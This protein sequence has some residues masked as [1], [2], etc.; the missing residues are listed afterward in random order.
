MAYRSVIAVVQLGDQ[1]VCFYIPQGREMPSFSYHT[2]R[3]SW[4]TMG[5]RLVESTKLLLQGQG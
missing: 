3:V 1:D 4:V 5:A 2:V